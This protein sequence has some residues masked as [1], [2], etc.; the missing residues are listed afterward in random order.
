MATAP[1]TTQ[2]L[3]PPPQSRST[4]DLLTD[5]QREFTLTGAD[6]TATG[7]PLTPLAGVTEPATERFPQLSWQPLTGAAYYKVQVSET[8]GYWLP[9][10]ATA[11]LSQHNLYP[12]ATDLSTY[13]DRPGTYTWQVAAYDAGNAWLGTG[14][15]STFTIASPQ[16]VTGQQI[17]LDGLD[18]DNG[19]VCANAIANGDPPCDNV[20]A[21]PVLDWNSV[22]GA[23]GY[24]VYVSEDPDLTNDLTVAR[25]FD[26]GMTGPPMHINMDFI[27]GSLTE[28]VGGVASA[29]VLFG[30]AWWAP[31]ILGGAW[32]GTHYLL[33][34]SSIWRDRNTD[35]VKE[36]QRH[37]DYTYRLAVDPPA[38]KEIRL[39]GLDDW[40]IDR[41]A[42]NRRRLVDP[43]APSEH[44]LNRQN[45]DVGAR[46]IEHF[47]QR[48]AQHVRE[49]GIL[50]RPLAVLVGDAL[51]D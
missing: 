11:F 4:D 44:I 31:I 14:P 49:A 33:R 26:F 10:S 29:A 17:A 35:E 47:E 51:L 32:I 36:A 41:F 50:E 28:M 37:A 48:F 46:G 12:T 8:P 3:P 13:F 22:P 16:V 27:A 24:V 34:E 9:E 40:A 23:D 19:H 6:P 20:P 2:G 15:T 5:W 21:T 30:Y 18:L 1:T 25:E 38:A 39:F 7:T 42:R 43:V 45:Q